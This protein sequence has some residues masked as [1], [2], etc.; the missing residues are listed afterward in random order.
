[1]E[2]AF[3]QTPEHINRECTLPCEVNP[4][5]I[6]LNPLV[7]GT[8][9]EETIRQ[10]LRTIILPH[11]ARKLKGKKREPLKVLS[12]PY[13]CGRVLEAD[14][15]ITINGQ[16]H[17]LIIKGVGCT[18]KARTTGSDNPWMPR[19]HRSFKESDRQALSQFPFL[20]CL[21]ILH[22]KHAME[23]LQAVIQFQNMGVDTEK[24]LAIYEITHMPDEKGNLRTVSYF[25]KKGRIYPDAQPVLMVRAVKSNF[26]L[27]DLMILEEL[28]KTESIA[29]LVDHVLHEAR[30]LIGPA[31]AS[32][33][34]YFLWL[35]RKV[36]SQEL[37]LILRGFEMSPGRWQC[38][39]RNIS[40]FGEELD[41]E[42]VKRSKWVFNSTY[43]YLEEVE[44]HARN[45]FTVLNFFGRAI[46]INTAHQLDYHEFANVYF[47]AAEGVLEAFNLRWLADKIKRKGNRKWAPDLDDL[48]RAVYSIF[49][50]YTICGDQGSILEKRMKERI[51]TVM[52]V[53]D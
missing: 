16:E 15:T 37:P 12:S 21:G 52:E 26:R 25:K 6:Y 45:I 31:A 42:D 3:Y 36:I 43:G 18:N 14:N 10:H 38:L 2:S 27:M 39:S 49:L 35:V 22:R 50:N 32:V 24:I 11:H 19:M 20:D 28:G 48:R 29:P 46:Y 30:Y 47:E 53:Y 9:L 1:M 17:V 40:V 23:E 7:E 44:R 4:H 51:G 41:L 33:Q 8:S 34:D 13:E 5:P